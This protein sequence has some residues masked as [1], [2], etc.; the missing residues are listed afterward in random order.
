MTI[1]EI[2]AFG[3]TLDANGQK[4]EMA[5]SALSRTIMKLF[6][7]PEEIAKTVGL[8]VEQF[9]ATLNE[10]TNEGL[11]MFLERLQCS[12]DTVSSPDS[13]RA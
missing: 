6:Q 13:D 7:A 1:P 11:L 4:V 5:A 8:D 3:A 10:S 2:L 12:Y 9:V